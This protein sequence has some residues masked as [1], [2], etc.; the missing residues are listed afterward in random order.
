MGA[1]RAPFVFCLALACTVLHA[2]AQ[3]PT[4]PDEKAE[5]RKNQKVQLIHVEDGGAVID[6]VRYAGQT[7]SITVKPK[8]G[9]RE[10]QIQPVSGQRVWNVF[11][12]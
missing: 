6:E 9:V 11:K 7:Q 5:G 1:M 2:Q 10:Y 12:F 3:A 4:P 8:A